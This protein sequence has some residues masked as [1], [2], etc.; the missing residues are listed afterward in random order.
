VL[1]RKSVAP[2]VIATSRFFGLDDVETDPPDPDDEDARALGDLR[3][4]EHSADAGKN[5]TAHE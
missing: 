5:A 4:V 1:S 2:N 3:P